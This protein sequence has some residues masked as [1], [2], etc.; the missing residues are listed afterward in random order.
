M[1]HAS[2][3]ELI[4]SGG[5]VISW[6]QS[7]PLCVNGQLF[8]SASH[9]HS[10]CYSCRAHICGVCRQPASVCPPE[11]SEYARC[12]NTKSLPWPQPAA[13]RDADD[14]R[15]LSMQTVTVQ[16]PQPK[17]DWR[18]VHVRRASSSQ[19]PSD[20]T[21]PA[22]SQ[23]IGVRVPTRKEV[24][25]QQEVARPAADLPSPRVPASAALGQAADSPA[26][27]DRACA[28]IVQ[29]AIAAAEA[30]A[31]NATDRT[32][33]STSVPDRS[34]SLPAGDHDV[35]TSHTTEDNQRDLAMQ[36]GWPAASP[37][38]VSPSQPAQDTPAFSQIDTRHA[39][40]PRPETLSTPRAAAPHPAPGQYRPDIGQH[41]FH[42]LL[43]HAP[44]A[45]H[46]ATCHFNSPL[47]LL[48]ATAER[49]W[50]LNK[51][52]A[53]TFWGAL[54]QASASDQPV[55]YALNRLLAQRATSENSAA[56]DQ[57]YRAFLDVVQ[58]RQRHRN[59]RDQQ[60]AQSTLRLIMGHFAAHGPVASL[61]GFENVYQCP[62]DRIPTED[63][64]VR[65]S[66]FLKLTLFF[67][68]T[69]SVQEQV[70]A[71]AEQFQLHGARPV[72][73][74]ATGQHYEYGGVNHYIVMRVRQG[75]QDT[76]IRYRL[77][78]VLTTPSS[79]AGPVGHFIAYVR[80]VVTDHWHLA[81]GRSCR[82]VD[83]GSYRALCR[84]VVHSR[85]SALFYEKLPD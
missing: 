25:V 59:L 12:W 68:H 22:P 35:S 52:P 61:F 85:V 15:R 17:P 62:P 11:K 67:E 7:C 50:F 30:R 57:S 47:E 33:R 82:Q 79:A 53:R 56:L 80:H 42:S 72:L 71:Y 46:F 31:R 13:G 20:T 14:G 2:A 18:H 45:T 16:I 49:T 28:D 75:E 60:D 84:H 23:G 58:S 74:L 51:D 1:V 8:Y 54:S 39:T 43:A 83:D 40:P 55:L 41:M 81:D 73:V 19:F 36:A 21:P 29:Q 32:R 64:V 34:E 65:P 38:T 26:E 76:L 66:V 24:R 3:G 6:K 9:R 5:Q 10:K 78:G 44:S 27:Q 77:F 63:D 69:A 48:R 70:I 4:L 37:P